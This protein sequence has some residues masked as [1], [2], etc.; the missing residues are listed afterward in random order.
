MITLFEGKTANAVW[1]NAVERFHDGSSILSQASRAGRTKEL[2][3]AA[4]TI[5]DPRQRWITMREPGINPAF[6]IAEVVWIMAGRRDSSFLLPWNSQLPNFI[7][8]ATEYHGA[9]GYRFR[10]H[11]GRD[12]L[13]Q[14]FHALLHNPDSRQAVLQIWDT[15]IDLPD[16]DGKPRDSD[17]PCNIVSMLKIRENRLEWT[18]IMRSN[19]LIRG[20]PYN[21]IQ[22][23]TLQEV[24]AGWLGIEVGSYNHFSDSLHVY[25][26]DIDSLSKTLNIGEEQ[27]TD[28]LNLSKDQSDL[29]FMEMAKAIEKMASSE[30]TPKDLEKIVSQTEVNPQYMNML[31]VV[32]AEAA[33]R[34]GWEEMIDVLMWGCTNPMLIQAWFR[35][36][37]RFGKSKDNL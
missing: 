19:D 35:W 36:I 20:V 4:F 9:Y 37:S 10:K 8:N 17:I 14:I 33:R 1:K 5:K 31:M 28:V 22:F 24:M 21:F 11:F 6:A 16:V 27:N 26:S 34:R 32:A 3:H 12:Q 2:L 18:Q 7:G 15:R 25:E 13:D 29:V 30:L 23:T